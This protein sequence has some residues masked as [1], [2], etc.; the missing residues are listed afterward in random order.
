MEMPMLDE[1]E[2]LKV[3]QAYGAAFRMKGV[4]LDERFQPVR[5]LYHY[6]TGVYESNHNAIMHHRI[7]LYG[8]PCANCRKPLRTP[9]A[10]FCA[11]CGWKPIS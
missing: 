9:L 5:D 8:D 1:D 10:A 6:M 7:S 11:A 4:P 2:Y 3:D